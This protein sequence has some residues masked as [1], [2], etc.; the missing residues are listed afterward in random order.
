MEYFWKKK[1]I[2]S[3]VLSILV[4]WIH[5]SP[6]FVGYS[7][8]SGL[9]ALVQTLFTRT[10]C[11]VAVPMFFLLSGA[12]F[13]R[14]YSPQ[15]YAEK[16]KKTVWSLIIPYLL[17]NTINMLFSIITSYSF[18]S[19]YFTGREKFVFRSCYRPF[20]FLLCLIIFRFLSPV[21]YYVIKS[22]WSIIVTSIILIIVI[23]LNIN[24]T[25]DILYFASINT[26]YYFIGA[27]I[28]RYHFD[29]FKKRTC[30]SW[31]HIFGLALGLLYMFIMSYYKIKEYQV[32]RTFII[33][34]MVLSLWRLFDFFVPAIKMRNFYNHSFF[35]YAMHLNL[36]ACF[37]KI[38][39]IILP[40]K[41]VVV[42]MNFILT[43]ITTL[44]VIELFC[45]ILYRCCR[46]VYNLL[47]G[48]R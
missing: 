25:N 28:G 30:Y 8:D 33:V 18:L 43:T 27:V 45:T 38:Y 11:P 34:I 40:E 24:I 5:S 44:V 6:A 26:I 7:T 46:P 19:S 23:A 21:I 20:W 14:N 29:W 36:V 42:I 41:D 47:S 39:H 37:G 2:V 4:L 35:V 1:T 17:W 3:Y 16:M 31:L 15:K 13:F 48:N 9:V 22:K 32:I 12:V 10:L